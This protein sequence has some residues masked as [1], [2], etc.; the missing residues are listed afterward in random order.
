[1][2]FDFMQMLLTNPARMQQRTVG[3]QILKNMIV[4]FS[5]KMNF[6]R[7]NFFDSTI[8]NGVDIID[9]YYF[10]SSLIKQNNITHR[11]KKR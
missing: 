4:T 1:M 7:P 9:I 2:F 3:K 10:A 8:L 6:L 5:T 11:Q